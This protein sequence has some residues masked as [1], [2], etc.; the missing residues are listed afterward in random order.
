MSDDHSEPSMLLRLAVSLFDENIITLVRLDEDDK[1]FC[2]SM[3]VALNFV[4][5]EEGF[6][7]STELFPADVKG[8]VNRMN[9]F[10]A[11]RDDI[12]RWD[13]F[14]FADHTMMAYL[15]V[16]FDLDQAKDE[17]EVGLEELKNIIVDFSE[18]EM[19]PLDNSECTLNF[20]WL[21]R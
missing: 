17:I 14:E 12:I 10:L 19:V 8:Y 9:H 2:I 13:I 18:E 16:S 20:M 7:L 6:L 1:L 5:D 15:R 3:P 21:Y 11:Q 4:E